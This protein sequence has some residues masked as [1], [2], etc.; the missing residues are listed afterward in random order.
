MIRKAFI[1]DIHG[2][3]EELELLYKMLGYESI[4]EIHHSGDLVDRGPDSGAVVSFCREHKMPGVMGNHEDSIMTWRERVKSGSV[5]K[6][7]DKA[8]T[9]S[10]LIDE[11]DW[12]YLADLPPLIVHDDLKY[13]SVHAGLWA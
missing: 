10:Q 9:L 8:R 12:Q 6:N 2:C 5:P 7:K 13:V 1:G 4:D 3:I 11:R